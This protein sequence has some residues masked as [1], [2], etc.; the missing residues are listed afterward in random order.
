M[1]QSVIRCPLRGLTLV[2][3]PTPGF[4]PVLVGGPDALA[5]D[6]GDTSSL[7]IE[8]EPDVGSGAYYVG[9]FDGADI[10]VGHLVTG[11]A[12]A[13]KARG[14]LGGDFDGECLVGFWDGTLAATK[15]QADENSLLWD[16]YRVDA[17]EGSTYAYTGP[18]F[19]EVPDFGFLA[20]DDANTWSF[21]QTSEF[22]SPP[23]F[24]LNN[25]R[26]GTV[27]GYIQA[28]D[29][30]GNV[31]GEY[32]LRITSFELII[33]HAPIPSP[34]P[35]TFGDPEYVPVYTD[36]L[37][38]PNLVDLEDV[39]GQ[40]SKANVSEN[41]TR[42]GL[43]GGS[44]HPWS[45]SGIDAFWDELIRTR[46]PNDGFASTSDVANGLYVTFVFEGL[47]ATGTPRVN[48]QN[49]MSI[50]KH[51]PYSYNSYINTSAVGSTPVYDHQRATIGESGDPL[52]DYAGL[53]NTS[54]TT[55]EWGRFVP[56]E[57]GGGEYVANYK[58]DVAKF[59]IR[60]W[61]VDSATGDNY[62][63][64]ATRLMKL[65]AY[66]YTEVMNAVTPDEINTYSTD[67][68]I[69][70]DSRADG[71]EAHYEYYTWPTI[72]GDALSTGAVLDKL[73]EVEVPA[74]YTDINSSDYVDVTDRMELDAHGQPCVFV[75]FL[76]NDQHLPHPFVV[77]T[78]SV[79]GSFER[80]IHG[81]IGARYEMD[82]PDRRFVYR[83][84]APLNNDVPPVLTT[85]I[86]EHRVRWF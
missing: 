49:R 51:V 76:Q 27:K 12:L 35:L 74:V 59:E 52:W 11:M 43:G 6:D 85:R 64:H 84:L 61:N 77:G 50:W 86:N 66:D 39:Y 29:F 5:S 73:T 33:R 68:S 47:T 40:S 55:T 56:D 36:Y 42:T 48:L 44:G 60:L 2:G 46:A 23:A 22:G 82:F 75:H 71:V 41:E 18:T 25:L 34:Y 24:T 21:N 16:D 63:A 67:L 65:E 70:I 69:L 14:G 28:H 78:F 15:D 57:L 53:V 10:P 38:V 3:T 19:P 17:D 58:L 26:A 1:A 7:T 8:P 32:V 54:D 4:E 13:V 81:S 45:Q 30:W 83:D 20:I 9:T 37:P 31:P 80:S 79:N 72:A 62:S